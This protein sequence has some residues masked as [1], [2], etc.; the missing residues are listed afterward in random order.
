V[1]PLLPENQPAALGVSGEW[2]HYEMLNTKTNNERLSYRHYGE[3]GK[4]K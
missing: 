1:N 3:K 4:M 2:D